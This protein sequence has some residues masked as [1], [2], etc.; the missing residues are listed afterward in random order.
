MFYTIE[1]VLKYTFFLLP[2]SSLTLYQN[3][4]SDLLT[5][6]LKNIQNHS[7]PLPNRSLQGWAFRLCMKDKKHKKETLLFFVLTFF[8]LLKENLLNTND[9]YE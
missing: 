3:E 4:T 9:S 5:L 8:L 2:Y 6:F 7:E 1:N